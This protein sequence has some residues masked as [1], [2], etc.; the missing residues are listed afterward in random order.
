MDGR[1]EGS[2]RPQALALRASLGIGEE[3]IQL[4]SCPVSGC[5]NAGAGHGPRRALWRRRGGRAR[6]RLR[7]GRG[8]GSA[9]RARRRRM[10]PRS[11][12][13]QPAPEARMLR[14]T[15]GEVVHAAAA[16]S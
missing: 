16:F 7:S 13:A 10:V 8:A 14:V 15:G 2:G 5:S 11:G 9:R 4:P 3:A 1:N 12:S 6:G